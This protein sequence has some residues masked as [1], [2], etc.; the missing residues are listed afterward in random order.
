MKIIWIGQRAYDWVGLHHLYEAT[1]VICCDDGSEFNELEKIIGAKIYSLERTLGERKKW[2]NFTITDAVKEFNS[3]LEICGTHILPYRVNKLIIKVGEKYNKPIIA[4]TL[5]IV[6]QLDNKLLAFQLLN[7]TKGINQPTSEIINPRFSTYD[8]LVGQ[9]GEQFVTKYAKSAS[10][11]G[12][13]LIKNEQQFKSFLD[14]RFPQN[15]LISEYMDFHSFNIHCV[16]YKGEIILSPPSLQIANSNELGSSW[17]EYCGNDFSIMDSIDPKTKEHIF[18]QSQCIGKKLLELGYRGILGLDF[19]ANNLGAWLVDIN[20]RFQGSTSLLTQLEIQSGINPTSLFH[21][22]EFTS[23]E[24]I[25]KSSYANRQYS[26]LYGGQL[27]YR[28]KSNGIAGE[29]ILP[30][31]YKLNKLNSLEFSRSGIEIAELEHENEFLIT[32]GIPRKGTIY[33]KGTSLFKI[34]SSASFLDTVTKQFSQKTK[35]LLKQ[36]Y[37]LV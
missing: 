32:C 17:G 36:V 37:S 29:Q 8:D 34:F 18:F 35:S 27:I 16:L 7:G 31:I 5:Q 6:E 9:W 22:L 14:Q 13:A 33:G 12:T 23:D 20:P 2:S 3:Q 10:G 11:S 1:S 25:P 28:S 15:I 24:T 21:I 26:K 19:L 30:G 4:P